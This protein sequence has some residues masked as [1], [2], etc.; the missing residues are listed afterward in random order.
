M[1]LE[2]RH[3]IQ[4]LDRKGLKLDLID[5][6]LSGTDGQD[7]DEWPSIKYWLYQL[8]LG[9]IDLKTPHVRGDPPLTIS[10]PRF[11]RFSEN[12]LLPRSG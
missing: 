12:T 9:R 3:V 10:R 2:Q 8:K 5:A 6:E 7:V 4:F 1:D 11:S